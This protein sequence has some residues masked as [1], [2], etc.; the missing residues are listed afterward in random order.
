MGI[1]APDGDDV[2]FDTHVHFDGIGG[3]TEA[4]AVIAR[5]CAAGV[6]RMAAIGGRPE[7]DD[8]AAAVAAA[9]PDLVV[10]VAGLDRDQAMAI[11]AHADAVAAAVCD[12][13]TR[14][15]AQARSGVRVAALGELGLDYYHTRETM[16]AQRSLLEAELALAARRSL[17]IVI[18]TREADADTLACLR[19]HA[20]SW[21][22]AP[23]RLGVLHCFTGTR[24]F[25][26]QLLDL[27]LCISFSGIVTFRNAAA[28]RDVVRLIPD[29]RLLIET[30]SPYLAPVPV[31]GCRNEPAWLPHVAACLAAERG[32]SVEHIADIT[33]GNAVRLFRPPLGGA[34]A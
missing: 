33:T 10:A 30:D 22:G 34:V 20:G 5:A 28:L 23:D 9:Y 32:V 6:T 21:A 16:P 25:A 11:G 27:G 24:D 17:P 26:V 31:R 15:D 3:M 2:F 4:A 18:H 19:V 13:E 14:I 8:T 29:D 12:L 7:A 1:P